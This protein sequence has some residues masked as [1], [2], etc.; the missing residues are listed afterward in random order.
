MKIWFYR[1]L[2]S[3]I[4]FAF[5]SSCFRCFR[6]QFETKL[7]DLWQSVQR[8]RNRGS[9]FLG[10]FVCLNVT[11]GFHSKS[12]GDNFW[13]SRFE[14]TFLIF[15]IRSR[16]QFFSYLSHQQVYQCMKWNGRFKSKRYVLI[17]PYLYN[18]L[19]SIFLRMLQWRFFKLEVIFAADSLYQ[20]F[21]NNCW[22]FLA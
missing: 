13:D 8:F 22:T 3:K 6:K 14:F 7:L 4:S 9:L 1:R 2:Q 17:L 11:A 20:L 21:W 15:S 18:R 19:P 10:S 16:V 5:F 12:S